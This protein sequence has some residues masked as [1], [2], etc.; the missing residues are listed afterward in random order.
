MSRNQV[1]SRPEGN[2]GDVNRRRK[3]TDKD[4]GQIARI[5]GTESANRGSAE[6][7]GVNARF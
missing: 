4:E 6:E 1:L 3:L 2:R 7:E 5:E